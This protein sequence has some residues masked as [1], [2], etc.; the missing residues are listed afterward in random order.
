[1]RWHGCF[2]FFTLWSVHHS[3]TGHYLL[4]LSVTLWSRTLQVSWCTCSKCNLAFLRFASCGEA[5]EVIL[6]SSDGCLWHVC[7]HILK[8]LLQTVGTVVKGFFFN[9]PLLLLL[10]SS[11]PNMHTKCLSY[12]T[13]FLKNSASWWP[14]LLTLTLLWSLC[15]ETTTDPKCKCHS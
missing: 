13:D 4:Y 2:Y 9:H 6:V 14:T 15:W 3:C 7:A 10:L 1:M 12:N 11:I 8:S 5:T